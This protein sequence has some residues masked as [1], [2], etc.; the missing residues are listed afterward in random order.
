VAGAGAGG[1]DC[2]GGFLDGFNFFASCENWGLLRL[3]DPA[4]FSRL[5]RFWNQPAAW[6]EADRGARPGR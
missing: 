1:I 4:G 3:R 2:G 6:L 5:A